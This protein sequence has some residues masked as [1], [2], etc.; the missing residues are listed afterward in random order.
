M[1][2]GAV[3][4]IL[5][6]DSPFEVH[7]QVF[8]EGVEKRGGYIPTPVPT[9]ETDK[10]VQEGRAV[11]IAIDDGMAAYRHMYVFG[12]EALST[13]YIGYYYFPK[14]PL[15]REI[16][17]GLTALQESGILQK[18]TFYY[19][20]CLFKNKW[21]TTVCFKQLKNVAEWPLMRNERIMLRERSINEPVI[22]GMS[23]FTPM[24]VILII[25]LSITTLLFLPEW[26]AKR[27]LY[28]DKRLQI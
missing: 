24:L 15:K 9:A 20:N 4:T 25:G 7:R 3:M 16:D 22:I 23:H 8:K 1:T 27:T 21:T 11:G 6:R 5:L 12:K 10:R 18:V 19:L 17:N 26:I 14:F 28:N 2:E 13:G